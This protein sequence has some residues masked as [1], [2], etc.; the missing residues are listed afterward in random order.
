MSHSGSYHVF[1]P[2]PGELA[3]SALKDLHG[4][5]PAADGSDRYRLV[6]HDVGGVMPGTR[7]ECLDAAEHAWWAWRRPNSRPSASPLPSTLRD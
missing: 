7:D 5:I 4:A 1:E 6:D 3:R 2:R